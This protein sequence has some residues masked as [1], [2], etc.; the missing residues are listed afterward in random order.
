VPELL[1]RILWPSQINNSL[2][3]LLTKPRPEYEGGLALETLT[4]GKGLD[5]IVDFFDKPLHISV[6]MK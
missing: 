3:S 6:I 4:P 5:A 2:N 1:D